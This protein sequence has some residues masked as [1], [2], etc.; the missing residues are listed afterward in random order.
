M[1]FATER[2]LERQMQY[3]AEMRAMFS[4]PLLPKSFLCITGLSDDSLGPARDSRTPLWTRHMLGVQEAE[5]DRRRQRRR[6]R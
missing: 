1:D 4:K 3:R 5:R 2:F 6:R